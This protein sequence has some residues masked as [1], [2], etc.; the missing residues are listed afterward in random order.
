MVLKPR[1]GSRSAELCCCRST[2]ELKRTFARLSKRPWFRKHGL[3]VQELA[4]PP[5]VEWRLIVAAGAVVGAVGDRP[6]LPSERACA[7][8]V[9]AAS[10]VGIDLVGVDLLPSADGYSVS[11]LDACADLA[12]DYSLAAGDLYADV[13][14]ALLFP[15]VRE[16]PTL[17]PDP[18]GELPLL[19]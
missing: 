8:A 18:D 13:V 14:E 2:R 16:L 3:L 10:A 5:G 4:P 15:H 1:F 12:A 19:R 11:E 6:T 9:G 7:I 17:R